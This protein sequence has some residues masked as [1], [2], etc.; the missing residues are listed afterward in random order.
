M[1]YHELKSHYFLYL[2]RHGGWDALRANVLEPDRPSAEGSERPRRQGRLLALELAYDRAEIDRIVSSIDSGTVRPRYQSDLFE[3][4]D[5]VRLDREVPGLE[6]SPARLIYNPETG[7][8]QCLSPA[9]AE[10]LARCDGS[11]TLEQVVAA[12]PPSV[13]HEAERC[14]REIARA[15]LLAP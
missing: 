3:P 9:A 4:E 10:I 11:R 1:L 5:L 12:F 14:V 15:G 2:V 13:R 6:P 8:L 7:E